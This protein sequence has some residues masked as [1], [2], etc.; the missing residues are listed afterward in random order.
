MQDFDSTITC[1]FCKCGENHVGMQMIGER[2]AS[3]TG[4]NLFDLRRGCQWCKA[5]G[6][7]YELWDLGLD[8]EE[9]ETP[10]A[11]ILIMRGCTS[12]IVNSK[13][14]FNELRELDWDKKFKSYGTVKDKHIRHNLIFADPPYAPQEPNYES[15][16]GRIIEYNDLPLL[17]KVRATLPEILGPKARDMICEGNHYHLPGKTGIGWHGD[18]ERR[19]VIGVRLG[20]SM[21]LKFRWYHNRLP[22][23][24]TMEFELHHGDIYVMSECAVGTEWK[25][26]TLYTL[27]HCGGSN[28]KGKPFV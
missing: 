26:P 25:K 3:G 19:R 14:L 15:G 22:V 5:N 2:E 8:L 21:N 4:F 7:E 28:T 12:V 23:G 20:N 1:T 6:V 9:I 10:A 13:L 11:Y 27:R 16:S 24:N 18:T 17:S